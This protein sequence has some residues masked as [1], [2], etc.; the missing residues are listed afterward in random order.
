M[1]AE[2]ANEPHNLKIG[3]RSKPGIDFRKQHR[4]ENQA[5]RPVLS[6]LSHRRSIPGKPRLYKANS[7]SNAIFN[8]SDIDIS[9]GDHRPKRLLSRL[10]F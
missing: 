4:V 9:M 7:G 2:T 3:V 5:Y 8:Q 1:G 10:S 6:S